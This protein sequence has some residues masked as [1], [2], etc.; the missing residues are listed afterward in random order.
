M[1]A[2]R[3]WFYAAAVYNTV[4]G[5]GAVTL[6]SSTGWRVVGMFVLVYAPAYVWVARYP[7]RHAHLVLV[8]MLGKILGP[9]G[10]AYGVS[11]GVLGPSYALIVV[12]ND[13]VW[14]PPFAGYLRAAARASG[15]WR[16]LLCGYAP[17]SSR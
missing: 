4:W 17:S 2:Y 15:G 8:A 3:R 6:A 10:F 5:C 12:A 14:W 13:I 11:T 1:S 9:V 16:A 7:E